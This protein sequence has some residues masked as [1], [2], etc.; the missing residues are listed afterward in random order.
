MVALFEKVEYTVL[1][2]WLFRR[3]RAGKVAPTSDP[4]RFEAPDL[5][6]F[7][8][9]PTEVSNFWERTWELDGQTI[10]VALH[11]DGSEAHAEEYSEAVAAI[12]EAARDM[13]GELPDFDYG[14]YTFLG[15]YLPWVAGD[16]ME[17]RNSTVL[18]STGSLATAMTGVLGTVA[19]FI[20][21]LRPCPLYL[22]RMVIRESCQL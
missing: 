15:C 2:T 21:K 6:Y 12:V 13:Y 16:G 7:L 9:S 4:F 11:H 5:Q 18:T 3:E 14:E 22:E 19:Q 20:R 1:L 8:D 10:R 17:H